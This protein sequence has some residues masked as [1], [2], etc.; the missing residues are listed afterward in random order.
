MPKDNQHITFL[1][2]YFNSLLNPDI[3]TETTKQTAI[4]CNAAHIPP[5]TSGVDGVDSQIVGRY[6]WTLILMISHEANVN[7]D[8]SAN[9]EDALVTN[10]EQSASNSGS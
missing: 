9:V 6:E 5:T 7:T 4:R 1:N 3:L 10:L 2:N 8:I